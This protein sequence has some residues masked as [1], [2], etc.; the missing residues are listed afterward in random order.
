MLGLAPLPRTLGAALRDARHEKVE[1]RL[2]AL[3]DLARLARDGRSEAEAE[4]VRALR[5]DRAEDVRVRAALGLADADARAALEAVIASARE[6]SSSRVRQF[7]VLALGELA[8]E[9]D[10]R[11]IE[12]LAAA[13]RDAEAPV[14]F[15]ALLSLH[16][17][18]GEAKAA[19]V[20]G[21]TDPD[22]E[23][24]RLAYRLAEAEFDASDFPELVR[25]R[26]RAA[27]GSEP[28]VRVAAALALGR[29]GDTSGEAILLGIVR[30]VQPGAGFE[31]QQAAIEL[32]ARLELREAE[33]ALERR[34][35]GLFP[36]DP[37]AFDARIA[38]ARL[39]N[40]RAKVA[41][42]RGLRA[43][44]FRARTLAAEAAGRA[45]LT[46][47]LPLLEALKQTPRRADA[48]VVSRALARLFG[49]EPAGEGA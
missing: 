22:A 28:G 11:V 26:A 41:I 19:I 31:E 9:R 42:L 44:S 15:Q 16:Q 33:P 46:E 47:A 25:A 4:L 45:R 1:V 40:A 21:M 35:F 17:V 30:G 20:E 23:I 49:A 14:R 18:A 34:A 8:P 43:W 48:E 29:F 12:L 6:E 5:E 7:A 39:G 38:L 3:G 10:P 27:L 13:C 32:V 24:R 37:L 2:S 36:R